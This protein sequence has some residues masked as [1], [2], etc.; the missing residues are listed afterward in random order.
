MGLAFE[1]ARAGLQSPDDLDRTTRRLAEK[2]IE[3]AESGV[4]DPNQLCDY[5]LEQFRG[6]ASTEAPLPPAAP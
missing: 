6:F 4:T 5:A 3:L 2:I 1:M